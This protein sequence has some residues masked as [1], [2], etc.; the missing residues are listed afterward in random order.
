MQ[1]DGILESGSL[2]RSLYRCVDV[3]DLEGCPCT[4]PVV[5]FTSIGFFIVAVFA[6][7][8]A[9]TYVY[10][11]TVNLG[12]AILD[13]DDYANSSSGFSVIFVISSFFNAFLSEFQ[14]L[15]IIR[16]VGA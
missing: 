3:P 9:S 8:L 16:N 7:F 12:A 5:S 10:N 14:R 15:V 2:Q 4:N 6:P 11:S 1:S 13:I